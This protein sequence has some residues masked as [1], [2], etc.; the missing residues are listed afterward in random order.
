MNELAVVLFL[1]VK[2]ENLMFRLGRIKLID[3][4]LEGLLRLAVG[5][6]ATA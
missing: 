4:F 1:G 5:T 2:R 3:E 6:P